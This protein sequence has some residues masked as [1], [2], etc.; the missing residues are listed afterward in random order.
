M[1]TTITPIRV[2]SVLPADLSMAVRY[3]IGDEFF[4]CLVNSFD[5]SI[6]Q[7]CGLVVY[8]YGL[9]RPELLAV[10]QQAAQNKGSSPFFIVAAS[11]ISFITDP[12]LN[13]VLTATFIRLDWL[14]ILQTLISRPPNSRDLLSALIP[15]GPT[16]RP[17]RSI[18]DQ[19]ELAVA[20]FLAHL[21]D[22]P[23]RDVQA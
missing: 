5:S 8:L 7:R 22:L 12:S 13:L 9:G 19:E 10:Y 15:H 14:Q 20:A 11:I 21:D 18:P 4:E 3:Q 2:L 1:T 16:L 17:S 23:V 6:E